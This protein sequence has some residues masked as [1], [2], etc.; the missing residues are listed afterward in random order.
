MHLR[1]EVGVVVVAVAEAST[2]QAFVAARCMLEASAV[3]RGVAP[4]IDT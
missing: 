2:L 3:E 1:F 4:G